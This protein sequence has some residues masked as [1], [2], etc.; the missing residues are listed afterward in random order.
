MRS[1]RWMPRRRR[2]RAAPRAGRGGRL[3]RGRSLVGT[4][5]LM[6]PI[7]TA[8][9]ASRRRSS[10][11]CSPRPRRS[12]SRDSPCVDTP[13]FWSPFGQVVIM[14]LIQLGGLGIM[15]FA[16]LI[17]LLLARRMSV[18]SRLNTAS[19]GEGG[20][21]RRRA[22]ARARHRADLAHRSR[23]RPSCC[24]SRGSCWGYGY[25]VGR[26]GVARHVPLGLVVQQRRLRAV[27]RQPHR[28][29]RA[30]RGSACRS[31]RAIILGGLGFPVHHAA[32]Q[33]V[34][35]GRCTGR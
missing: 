14:L 24:C 31:R 11:R 15:I 16:A 6:L 7:S 2:F 29:R 30:T 5:L 4:V 23:R 27:H 26:G 18:R 35:A 32:A 19:R 21:L 9:R 34:H 1:G 8:G 12:A 22:R 33:G 10:T 28:V 13:T 3:R 20:R 17:G 25:G